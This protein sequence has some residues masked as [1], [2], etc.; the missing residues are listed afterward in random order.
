VEGPKAYEEALATGRLERGGI[1]VIGI[2]SADEKARI[3]L[4]KSLEERERQNAIYEKFNAEIVKNVTKLT[5]EDEILSFMLFCNFDQ[6]YLLEVNPVDLLARI[7]EKY[8]EYLN[9]KES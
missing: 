5:D 7:A 8:E 9:T 4:Q 2:L 1:K 6:K 3:R